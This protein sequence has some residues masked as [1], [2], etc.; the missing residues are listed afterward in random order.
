VLCLVE[1]SPVLSVVENESDP[2]EV[3]LS[4]L[5]LRMMALSV[6]KSLCWIRSVRMAGIVSEEAVGNWSDESWNVSGVVIKVGTS[7]CLHNTNTR[8]DGQF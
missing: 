5:F 1:T 8:E 3:I 4:L 6:V 7:G 2:V